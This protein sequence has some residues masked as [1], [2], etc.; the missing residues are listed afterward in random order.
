MAWIRARQYFHVSSSVNFGSEQTE[1]P[2]LWNWYC[3]WGILQSKAVEYSTADPWGL[4]NH[5][6]TERKMCAWSYFCHVLGILS[7]GIAGTHTVMDFFI[8][9]IW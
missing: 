4:L 3:T 5:S 2:V 1:H 7:G 6:N 9:V 8:L